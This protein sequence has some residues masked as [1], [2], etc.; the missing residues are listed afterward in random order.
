MEQCQE[1]KFLPWSNQKYR[2]TLAGEVFENVKPIIPVNLSD[3]FYFELDWYDGKRLYKLDVIIALA[4]FNVKLPKELIAEVELLFKDGDKSNIALKNLAYRFK[5]G[6]LESR[7]FPGFFHIPYHTNYLLN[8]DGEVLSLLLFRKRKSVRLKKWTITRP[9]LNKRIT[10]G[11]RIGEVCRDVGEK[12][13]CS[14]HRF[15]ALVF[16]RYEADPFELVVNHKNGI[17]GDDRIQNLEWVTYS[18]N[19]QHAYDN[20]LHSKKVVKVVFLDENTGIEKKYSTIQNCVDENKFTFGFVVGRLKNQ[21]VR[22][23]DGLRFKVDNGDSWINPSKERKA[24]LYRTVLARNVFTGQIY[25]FESLASA[26]QHTGV[27]AATIGYHC[28][29]EITVPIAGYNF[30]Y[31]RDENYW[32]EHS[33]WHFKMYKNFPKG[34]IPKGVFLLD[35]ENNVVKL[36]ESFEKL[37]EETSIP[38][39]KLRSLIKNEGMLNG[40][41][42]RWFDANKPL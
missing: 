10:G 19:V 7:E 18:E 13:H 22:Y 35:T 2:L 21:D 38:E 29:N 42:A 4:Y 9:N 33:E 26:S 3:G 6:P 15:M 37:M 1:E 39:K 27:V 5:S 34:C 40:Y 31:L 41:R 17:P 32:P 20:N 14:R 11:Y 28:K 16:L 30:Q 8:K 23:S 25:I 36:Y 24:C 12:R